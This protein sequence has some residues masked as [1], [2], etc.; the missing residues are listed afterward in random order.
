[1]T[2]ARDLSKLLSTSNG[3]IAGSNLDVSFENISDTG[4]TGTKVASGTTAQRGSTAGQ[5][6]FNSTTGLAEYYTGSAFK[7]IDAPPTVTSLDVTEVDSQAGGNQTI[8]ITGSGFG[9]GAT[10]TFVGSSA[11]FNASTTTV[12]SITQITAVA[13]KSSFLNAQEPYSVKVLN[14]SGLSGILSGQI[15]VDTSPSWST[16]SGNLGTLIEGTTANVSVTA[17]DVDGDTIVYSVQSGSLPAGTSLNTSTGAITGTL[18]GVSADTTSS[19]TLR[20][21]AN[22]KTADRSFNMI[23]ADEGIL[24]TAEF[25]I[26]PSDSRSWSGSGSTLTNI[27]SYSNSSSTTNLSLNSNPVATSSGITSIVHTN[28]TGYNAPSATIGN[29]SGNLTNYTVAFFA[30]VD[31]TNSNADTGIFMY[32]NKTSNQAIGGNI[33]SGGTNQVAHYNYSNDSTFNQ[34]ASYNWLNWNFYVFR[35]VS[36]NKQFWLNNTRITSTATETNN[37]TS[38]PSNSRFDIG[39]RSAPGT[40]DNWDT[41]VGFV[42]IWTSAISDA[43]QTFLYNKFKGDYGL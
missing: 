39:G 41:R 20:A 21:T 5:I 43:E 30:K 37:A 18:S 27:T 4:T 6:R 25:Y 36:G 33:Y 23:T 13:P 38:L 11:S 1:M 10:V 7:I 26:D 22:T 34:S 16:A 3:K 9:S 31:S 24:G 17:T 42:G 28:S 32:G 15:N 19:F 35:K 29:I 8:V 40:Y 14:T 2:K 12:N